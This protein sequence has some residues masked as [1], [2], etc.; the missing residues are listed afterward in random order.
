M[1]ARAWVDGGRKKRRI[2]M[3]WRSPTLTGRFHTQVACLHGLE[4]ARAATDGER[5]AWRVKSS[6]V[7]V[8]PGFPSYVHVKPPC[9]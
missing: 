7:P 6:R 1:A 2:G 3:E 5:R 4:G 8:G 9:S